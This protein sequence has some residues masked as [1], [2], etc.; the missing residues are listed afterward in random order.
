MNIPQM[1]SVLKRNAT[2]IAHYEE[3]ITEYR[4]MLRTGAVPK[5]YTAFVYNRIS[6][7]RKKAKKLADIQV[8][9]KNDIK[10]Q[11]KH[12]NQDKYA[13][14]LLDILGIA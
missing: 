14:N 5:L 11:Q 10:L 1:Q 9:I 4:T 6:T 13:N 7:F 2:E 12:I 3:T 8:A